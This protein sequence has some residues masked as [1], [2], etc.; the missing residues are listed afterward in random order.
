MASGNVVAAAAAA[1]AAAAVVVVVVWTEVEWATQ[2]T[3][4]LAGKVPVFHTLGSYV[5]MNYTEEWE[6]PAVV[7]GHYIKN[8]QQTGCAVEVAAAAEQR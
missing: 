6:R 7:E 2:T 8:F 3:L 1:A 5:V 4:V